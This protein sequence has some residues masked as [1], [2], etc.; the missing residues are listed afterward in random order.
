LEHKWRPAEYGIEIIAEKIGNSTWT[1]GTKLVGS[2]DV[3]NEK[4]SV[5]VDVNYLA[6]NPEHPS[7]TITFLLAGKRLAED[8]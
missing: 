8:G 3:G 2:L 6:A 7:G 1:A 4:A 5:G